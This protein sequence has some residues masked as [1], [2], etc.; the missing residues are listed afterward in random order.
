M[1]KGKG[2]LFSSSEMLA[3]GP[4]ERMG[5]DICPEGHQ[6]P[7]SLGPNRGVE[8]EDQREVGGWGS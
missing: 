5:P 7:E 6:S 4:G 2:R 8:F 3:K 1:L